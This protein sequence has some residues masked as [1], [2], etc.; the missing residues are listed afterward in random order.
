MKSS[1]LESLKIFITYIA[2][3]LVGASTGA[4]FY[5]IYHT[6]TV[7]VAGEYITIDNFFY[8]FIPGLIVI[9]PYVFTVCAMF[10]IFH[11]VRHPSNNKLPVV[12]FFLICLFS[13]FIAAPFFNSY[14]IKYFNEFDSNSQKIVPASGFFRR[15][16]DNVVY[17][18]SVDSEN[19]AQGLCIDLSDDVREL[20]TFDNMKVQNTNESYTNSV[21]KN[22]FDIPPIINFFI[23]KALELRG[24]AV[25]ET[26]KGY[27]SWIYFASLGLSLMSLIS[28]RNLSRWR[29]INITITVYMVIALL[30][31]NIQAYKTNSF[32]SKIVVLFS[33]KFKFIPFVTNP[34][35]VICNFIVFIL[36][37]TIGQY[38]G[39]SRGLKMKKDK[40]GL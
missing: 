11:F 38:M 28:I 37:I 23:D 20:Y 10:L 25:T 39:A 17:Y 14:S 8:F 18:T 29:M 32:L 9:S 34:F 24:Y 30:T 12:T 15:A 22:S 3:C 7:I 2:L 31:L 4:I 16:G 13:W 36:F 35:I 5:S 19:K 1:I 26:E 21:I 33:D 27:L 6:S 40:A